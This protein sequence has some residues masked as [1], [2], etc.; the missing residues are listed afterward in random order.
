M[1]NV[2]TDERPSGIGGWLLVVAAQ[3]A[4][5]PFVMLPAPLFVIIGLARGTI[6][7][8]SAGHLTILG[9]FALV[10]L[11]YGL[12]GVA[13]S[14]ALNIIFY[15]KSSRFPRYFCWFYLAVIGA[16]IVICMLLLQLPR[17]PASSD[18]LVNL[19]RIALWALV[20]IL[21]ILRSRRVRNTFVE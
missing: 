12:S 1:S 6:T 15:R 2:A 8:H 3:L 5:A 13:A 19:G 18:P 16:N 11:A 4:L 10:S 17:V 20:W 7:L 14:V 9:L 21:Y